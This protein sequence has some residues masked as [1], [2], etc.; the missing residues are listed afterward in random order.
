M[1]D[2][3]LPYYTFYSNNRVY[4]DPQDVTEYKT[5]NDNLSPVN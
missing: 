4:F 2:K 5:K 3:V 1:K